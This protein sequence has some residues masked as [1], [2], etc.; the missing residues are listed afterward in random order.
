VKSGVISLSRAEHLGNAARDRGVGRR[1]PVWVADLD[2]RDSGLGQCTTGRV[3]SMSVGRGL[4][5]GVGHPPP[6]AWIWPPMKRR[7][8]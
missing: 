6:D 2:H 5:I 1:P 7:W 4:T 8:P 3:A